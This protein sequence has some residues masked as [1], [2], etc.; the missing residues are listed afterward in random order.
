[1]NCSRQLCLSFQ[2][3]LKLF[4]VY[5]LIEVIRVG[6]FYFLTSKQLDRQILKSSTFLLYWLFSIIYIIF[7]YFISF[8]YFFLLY[9]KK[10]VWSHY[11]LPLIHKRMI[12]EILVLTDVLRLSS[13]DDM[14]S[15]FP[16]YFG[17]YTLQSS[18]GRLWGNAQQLLE[19]HKWWIRGQCFS[20]RH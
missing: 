9:E 4:I 3:Y 12:V 1:M 6:C 2:L 14:E 10:I 7:H 8:K 13:M 5:L 15:S 16:Q 19:L 18:A 11:F 20:I 17:S